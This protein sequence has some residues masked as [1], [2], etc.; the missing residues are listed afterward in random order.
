MM[1]DDLNDYISLL[2]LVFI[3]LF[4]LRIFIGMLFTNEETRNGS[5]FKKFYNYSDNED[6]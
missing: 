4:S 5:I 2:V 6:E 1:L 3:S